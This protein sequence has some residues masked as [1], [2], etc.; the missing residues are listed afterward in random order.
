MIVFNNIYAYIIF[1]NLIDELLKNSH[2][3]INLFFR[4]LSDI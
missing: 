3:L 1:A 4:F 2:Q